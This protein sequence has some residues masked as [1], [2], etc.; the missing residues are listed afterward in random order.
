[1]TL[2]LF[3][4]FLFF[5]TSL[6]AQISPG[7][8]T[9]AHADLEGL[10]NCTKCHELG[11]KV[12]NSKCLDCHDEIEK[13]ITDARGYHSSGEVKSKNCNN[14]HPEHFG[15]NFRIVNFEP[16]SF[17]HNKANYK[18][19]GTHSKI[20]CELCHQPINIIDAEIRKRTGTFLGL[21]TNC[22]S[23]HEDYHQNTLGE[24]CV[25]CHDS[26]KFRPA[27]KFDHNK[28]GF[29]LVGNHVQV[30]CIKC[31]PMKQINGTEFQ[32]FKG[33]SFQSCSPCHTDVH[34]GKF[35]NNCKSCHVETSFTLINR[36]EFDHSRTNF[37]L[38]GK[39]KLIACEY[40]HFGGAKK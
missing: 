32:K 40:C 23:C 25:S 31:H 21:N 36:E 16:S 38:I 27:K 8:L 33:I 9:T 37:P 35:G 24:D 29:K 15:R 1:M 26:E 3:T 17:D 20:E 11:E 6:S 10:S 14:C 7:K 18:L 39:H 13:L 5:T 19:T 34:Q 30:D 28:A 12:I 4:C 2:K 22:I